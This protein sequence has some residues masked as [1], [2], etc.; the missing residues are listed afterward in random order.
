M[1]VSTSLRGLYAQ[2]TS[3]KKIL[4]PRILPEKRKKSTV[5]IFEKI[6]PYFRSLQSVRFKN[7]VTRHVGDFKEIE[8]KLLL[9]LV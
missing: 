5:S 1:I 9:N 8:I 4:E 7:E 3:A 2:V 6:R